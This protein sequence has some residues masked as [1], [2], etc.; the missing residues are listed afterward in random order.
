MKTPFYIVHY[1]RAPERRLYLEAAIINASGSESFDFRF[2]EKFDREDIRT[3]SVYTF[4]ELTYKRIVYPIKNVLI[5][6]VLGIFQLKNQSFKECVD[7][8]AS[9][10][11]SLELDF[12]FFRWLRPR[13][14][15]PSEISVFLKHRAVW[16]HIKYDNSEFC[17]IAEDDIIFKEDSLTVLLRLLQTLP[18][19]ADYVDIAGGCNLLPRIGNDIVNQSFFKVCPPRDRTLTCA[20]VRRSLVQRLLDLN[21]P[22]CIPVDWFWT[23]GF[24]MLDA[25]VYWIEPPVFSNGSELNAYKSTTHEI[26]YDLISR[27]ASCACGSGKRFKHCHGRYS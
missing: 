3:D 21:A 23:Y 14:L 24:K 22:I 11:T 6:Y 17:V 5:G 1:T 12:E 19:D 4:D 20:I 10:N 26:A 27:N 8:Y 9:Q 18:S 2:V 16:E 15:R 13:P 25:T 7:Y